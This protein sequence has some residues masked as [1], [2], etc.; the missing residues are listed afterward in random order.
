MEHDAE[1]RRCLLELDV[2][3]IRAL[4]QHLSPG[5]PQP[6][7]EDETLH[8]IHLA[9]V[10]MAT[11]PA[12]QRAYSEAWL[13]ER[14]TGR[15]VRAVGIAVGVHGDLDPVRRERTQELQSA[16]SEAVT[17]AIQDGVDLAT[18]TPEI[19]RR[20]REARQKLATW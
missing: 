4:W 6:Q 17:Q 2:A 7:S 20:M 8:T 18:E 5:L 3:G 12:Q 16:M 10:G 1:F 19:Q 14:Q 13:K 15:I 9:R 11:L